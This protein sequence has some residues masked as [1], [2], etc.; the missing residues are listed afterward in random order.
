M[1]TRQHTAKQ[2]KL[3]VYVG[4]SL[5]HAPEP[6]VA[7]VAELKDRL[8]K[9]YDVFDFLG[10]EKGTATDVYRWDIGRCVATCDFFVAIC[11]LTSLGLGYE[12]GSAIERFHKPVLA[13]ASEK[14]HLS[15]LIV[16]I[17]APNFSLQRYE[18][19]TEI[20]NMID[21]FVANEF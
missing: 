11:D 20:P 9:K 18:H 3:K 12:I 7:A 15:R 6:F 5:T 1:A 16:G 19:F 13:V 14:T 10:M 8:R 2:A 17:D 21:D 4:C